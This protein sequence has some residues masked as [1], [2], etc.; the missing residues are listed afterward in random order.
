VVLS[1]T[2]EP[3]DGNPI[4]YWEWDGYNKFGRAVGTGS[5]IAIFDITKTTESTEQ[6]EKE[7]IQKTIAVVR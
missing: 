4:L 3:T 2:V 1:E 7:V 5:Y 6:S